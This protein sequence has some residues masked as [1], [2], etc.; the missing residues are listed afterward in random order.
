MP[1]R[2]DFQCKDLHKLSE[3]KDIGYP[4]PE[5]SDY[6]FGQ[7]EIG[8]HQFTWRKGPSGARCERGQFS[9]NNADGQM[10]SNQANDRIF[11]WL[12]DNM[13]GRWH[14]DEEARG[15]SVRTRLWIEDATDVERFQREWGDIF[16]LSHHQHALNM[17]IR[18]AEEVGPDYQF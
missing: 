4:F 13:A 6:V 9:R 8:D 18:E 17:R 7:G 11:N 5:L 2:F 1:R 16:D 10:L 14:W 12:S 3:A 15:T